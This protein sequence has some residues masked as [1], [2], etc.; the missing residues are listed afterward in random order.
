MQAVSLW[1]GRQK[2][3]P[4][5]LSIIQWLATAET[6]STQ[7][8]SLIYYRNAHVLHFDSERALCVPALSSGPESRFT[9]DISDVFN[10]NPDDESCIRTAEPTRSQALMP[11]KDYSARAPSFLDFIALLS[12]CHRKSEYI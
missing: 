6:S 12:S 3:F 5:E 10:S 8:T 4:P 7:G 1:A 11:I 9:L 2:G